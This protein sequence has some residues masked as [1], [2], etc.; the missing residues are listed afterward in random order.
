MTSRNVA[1]V[2]AA[3]RAE[4]ARRCGLTGYPAEAIRARETKD[5]RRRGP[6]PGHGNR[7]PA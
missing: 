1:A 7:Q 5:R 6:L 2:L 3:L 4:A